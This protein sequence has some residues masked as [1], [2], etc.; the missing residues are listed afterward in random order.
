[1]KVNRQKFQAISFGKRG[2]G[3]ITDFKCRMTQVKCE[4]A[5]VLLGIAID[6]LLTF[7]DH[8]T[9]ICKK[10]ARQLAVLKRLGNLLT[11]QGKVAFLKS[12]ISSNVHYCPLI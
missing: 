10:S 3:V 2:N 5:V 7:N 9:D 8:M 12:F 4:D 1:M 11:L 6:R